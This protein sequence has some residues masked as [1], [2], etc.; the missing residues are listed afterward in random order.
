MTAA[1]VLRAVGASV[2]EAARVVRMRPRGR[3]GPLCRLSLIP[4]EATIE[5][6]SFTPIRASIMAFLVVDSGPEAG[7]KY[8]LSH[9]SYKLGR[10]PSCDIVI[11]VGAV[12]R[13]HAEIAWDGNGF[14]V[15]DLHSRNGTLLNDVPLPTDGRQTLKSGD[16][17]QVCDV[18]FRFHDDGPVIPPTMPGKAAEGSSPGSAPFAFP[19]AEGAML[20]DGDD[21]GST[22]MSKLDVSSGSRS[23]QLTATPE[24]KL[25]A[26]L[27]INR[28]LGKAVRLDD[29]LPQVLNSLFKI[30][31]QADRGF[32]VL[33][34]EDGNLVPRWSKT[35]R[36]NDDMIRISR[37]IVRHVME[38]KE[39]IL[40]ADA[41]KDFDMSQSL[42]DFRIRSMMCAPLLNSDGE[43]IGVLQMDTLDQ[44][45]RFMPEDLE[46]LAA[47]A[48]QAGIAIDNAQLHERSLWQKGLERDLELAHEVQRSFLPEI[49]PRI[50]GYEFYDYYQPANHVG[51][52]YFDYIHL[53]DGRLAIIVA[54][55]VGHGVA[56]ALLM[57][58]LSAETKF[59]L[60]SEPDPAKAVNQLNNSISGLPMDRFITLIMVVLDPKRNEVTIVNGG[61]MPPIVRRRDGSIEEPGEE[62]AGMPI[63]ILEGSEYES[64]T[65]PLGPGESFML[66]TDG[67]NEA[68]NS[69]D[70]QYGIPR[71]REHV[72][73]GGTLE[74]IGGDLIH[75]IEAFVGDGPQTDDMC[76]VFVRR[77]PG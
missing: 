15:R 63:G 44:R 61:H 2:V 35:R 72:Q 31:M 62:E 36:G 32:I 51:G 53:P 56:A 58:K 68:M 4:S 3:E 47:V 26:L 5:W 38:A 46:V 6:S 33:R 66:Y 49:R 69:A 29:V 7:R 57:A 74:Q 55:V 52:D 39:A 60:A 48:A 40:S 8:D 1:P 75:D 28:A 12:S 27:E 30:F 9:S 64:L 76:L 41:A 19:Q 59:Q 65:I 37:T 17:V 71:I 22:I 21:S 10:H 14:F 24:A 13:E 42:T 34:T 16:R 20:V 43:A 11:Q 50:P 45:K 18:G 25:A 77:L 54:D 73:S 23:V 70:E 67:L